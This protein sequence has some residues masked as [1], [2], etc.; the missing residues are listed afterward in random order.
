MMKPLTHKR[1]KILILLLVVL[2]LGIKLY[3][4][5]TYD[6]IVNFDSIY[7]ARIGGYVAENGWIPT[8]DWVPDTRPHLYPPMY[9][10]ILGYISII[11]N[12]PTTELVGFILPLVSTLIIL[13]VFFLVRRMRDQKTALFAAAIAAFN[14][15]IVAQSYDSPQ[16]FGLLLLPLLCYYFLKGNYF[17]SGGLLGICFLFNYLISFSIVA[18]L[19]FFG[20]AQYLK[21]KEG[22]LIYVGLTIAIGLGLSSPWLLYS[23]SRAAECFD[24]STAV[25]GIT[26]VGMGYLYPMIPFVAIIG[27]GLIYLLRDQKD[28]YVTFWKGVLFVGTVGFLVSLLF[29]QLHPY[30]M[31]LMFGFAAIFLAPE[32]KVLN[33]KYFKMAT[34]VILIIMSIAAMLWVKPALS[35]ADLSAV[36]WIIANAAG[37]NVLANPEVSGAINLLGTTKSIETEF[38]LFLECLPDSKRWEESFTALKTSDEDLAD[39]ILK[40]YEIDYV[41][42]GARDIWNYGFDIEKFSD[43]DMAIAYESGDSKIYT[44]K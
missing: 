24:P 4:P 29:T 2:S 37:S 39:E 1:T 19:V 41:I 13:P 5:L 33:R 43:M 11:T 32:L 20:L 36:G 25:V 9:H 14:P 6:F 44:T 12:I 3:P 22:D 21:N 16:L 40:K 10:L 15:I 30:D 31:L 7:H 42:V 23:A 18:I 38:D 34:I 35:E 17:V 27:L 8:N 28:D 26:E